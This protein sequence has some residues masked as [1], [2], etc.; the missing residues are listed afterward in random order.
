MIAI[1]PISTRNASKWIVI[2]LNKDI[3]TY[4]FTMG[5]YS[6]FERKLGVVDERWT[7]CE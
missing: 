3:K 5:D 4:N 7:T 1:F 6:D 2:V